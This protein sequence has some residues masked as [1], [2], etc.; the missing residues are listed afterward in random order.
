M[1]DSVVETTAG[2]VR[3]VRRDGVYIFKGIPYGAST[4]G[5]NRFKAPKLPTPWGGVHDALAFGPPPVQSPLPPPSRGVL[6]LPGGNPVQR[7]RSPLE[8]APDASE[9]CLHINVWTSG[10]DATQKRAVIVASPHTKWGSATGEYEALASRGDVVAVS[11]DNRKGIFGHL[12]L[13]E[14]G[15]EEYADSGNAA[16]LDYVL[17]L[18]WIHDN[19]AAFGGDPDRVLIWGCS[20]S[21]SETSDIT[22]TPMARGLFNRALI[23]DPGALG[24]PKFY[25]TMMA[26]RTLARLNIGVNELDKLLAV[27]WQ[28]LDETL[29]VFG[30]LAHCL[31]TPIPL[32]KFFQFYPVVDGVILPDEPY[33]ESCPA[34]SLDIPMIVGTSKNSLNM[35]LSSR[36]W[37]GRLDE[38]GLRV[39]AENH[40][41][42]DLA[43]AILAA[44]RRSQP[45]ASPTEIALAI[46]THRFCANAERIAMQREKAATAPT[47]MYRFDYTTP[48][49]DGLFGAIH[50][51]EFG[52]FLN[53]VDVGLGGGMFAGIY[54]DRADRHEV[55]RVLNE[56]FVRFA[57]DGDPNHPDLAEWTPCTTD[58]RATM[59]LD[60]ECRLVNDPDH[61][62]RQLFAQIDAM[63]GPGDYWRSLQQ[64][65]WVW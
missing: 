1:T 21:G 55:Q 2:K 20:G 3:G 52:F 26:E 46:A 40:V 10:L 49:A 6:A 42:P 17:A 5:E 18:Q 27:P 9:D 24:M 63:G 62:I 39:M 50:G 25:A 59:L 15:G 54:A 4:A 30:D 64:S 61:E 8:S 7:G 38:P 57:H 33:A 65:Q 56:A 45:A 58:D 23:S 14:I 44:E 47:F 41:G 34:A 36:P 22:A 28:Q 37:V 48:V 12:Y 32:Q 29:D 51:G 60:S 16:I 11:F 19:I 43:E 53:N 35:I 13:G 31:A